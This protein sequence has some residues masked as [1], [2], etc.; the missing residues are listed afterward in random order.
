MRFSTGFGNARV[1][2]EP[3]GGRT[4]AAFGGG[5]RPTTKAAAV[6]ARKLLS[7]GPRTFTLLN[8]LLASLTPKPPR[9]A[10]KPRQV[11]LKPDAP[12]VA[13]PSVVSP[14]AGDAITRYCTSPPRW[15][16]IITD[17]DRW[18]DL[19]PQER[20]ILNTMLQGTRHG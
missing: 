14:Y 6:R 10:P 16:E 8:E 20:S 2:H 4:A 5:R 11:R 1:H 7:F 15:S 18:G 3:G 19:T 12:P 13:Q 9:L 17:D